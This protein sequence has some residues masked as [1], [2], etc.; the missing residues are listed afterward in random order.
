M[1][2]DHSLAAVVTAGTSG[3]GEATVRM[4]RA[5]GVRVAILDLAIERGEQFARES[6][7]LD[8]AVRM[9]PR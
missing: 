4:L 2:L 7:R 8:G 3:L 6:I 1:K 5:T 9:P